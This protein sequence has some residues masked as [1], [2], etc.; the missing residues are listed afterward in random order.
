MKSRSP[1]FFLSGGINAVTCLKLWP[2]SN[3][4][5]TTGYDWVAV[6]RMNEE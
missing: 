6:A 2:W 5:S 4:V 1:Q 3:E